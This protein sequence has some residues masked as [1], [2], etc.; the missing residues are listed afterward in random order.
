MTLEETI[1]H[2]ESLHCCKVECSANKISL[3]VKTFKS[4]DINSFNHIKFLLKQEDYG[5]YSVD[6]VDDELCLYFIRKG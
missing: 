3:S 1:N 2:L 4:L 5:F 6:A